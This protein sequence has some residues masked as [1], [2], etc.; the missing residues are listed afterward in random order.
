M[1]HHALLLCLDCKKTLSIFALDFDANLIPVVGDNVYLKYYSQEKDSMVYITAKVVER[2]WNLE[3]ITESKD[4]I[5]MAQITEERASA[6]I[7]PT[8]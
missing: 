7:T 1:K 3:N 6:Y 4:I 5:L 2:N 8:G